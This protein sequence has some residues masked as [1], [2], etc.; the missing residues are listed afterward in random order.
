MMNHQMYSITP[1]LGEWFYD[2]EFRKID[3]SI[4]E[5]ER[6]LKEWGLKIIKEKI[7]QF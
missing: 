1:F 6:K 5:R 4:N 2:K 7:K 3:K